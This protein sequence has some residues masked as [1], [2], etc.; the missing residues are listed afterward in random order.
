MSRRTAFIRPGVRQAKISELVAKR[1]E[2]TVEALAE[3]FDASAETIRRDLTVLADAG[4][5]RKVH[6]GARSVTPRGEGEFDT[7]MRRNALAKR[8]I[9]EKLADLVT[10]HSTLFMDTGSTTLICAQ[11]L[12]RIKKLTVIT[13]STRIADTFAEGRGRADVYLLGGRYRGDNAQTVGDG[14]IRQIASYRAEMAIL[15]VGA[16]DAGGVMDYSSHE[17]QVARAMIE[18]SQKLCVVVDHSKFMRSATFSVC[19]LAEID[20]LV[21]DRAPDAAL[22]APL[23]FANVE[24]YG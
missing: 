12:A 14:V 1:G 8:Q 6:G 23:G 3:T 16:I 19:D 9:A 24:V 4:G 7:R 20:L 21:T 11:V 5:L 2:I 17:A 13:N 22:N 18:A 10:P 15:T